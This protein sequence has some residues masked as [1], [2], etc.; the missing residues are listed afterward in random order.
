M[1]KQILYYKSLW[2]GCTKVRMVCTIGTTR[3]EKKRENTK[4]MVPPL[5]WAQPIN[6]TSHG[7]WMVIHVHPNQFR[8]IPHKRRFD[9]LVHCSTSLNVLLF[10]SL[11]NVQNKNKG[12]VIQAFFRSH[13]ASMPTQEVSFYGRNYVN[14]NQGKI[15][16]EVTKW[17]KAREYTHLQWGVGQATSS[18]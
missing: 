7:H 11:H 14:H 10:L 9:R 6:E 2:K 16:N 13:K 4:N 15:L 5:L 8:K 17:K 3:Q 18:C 12:I 1:A